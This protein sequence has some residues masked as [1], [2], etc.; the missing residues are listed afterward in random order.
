MVGRMK[1]YKQYLVAVVASLLILTGCTQSQNQDVSDQQS[2]E[3]PEV[4]ETTVYPLYFNNDIREV[5]CQ[6]ALNMPLTVAVVDYTIGSAV[7]G[8]G[9]DF[10]SCTT[11]WSGRDAFLFQIPDYGIDEVVSV[12]EV[13]ENPPYLL[14]DDPREQTCR[15]L[16]PLPVKYIQLSNLVGTVQFTFEDDST[17]TAT[18]ISPTSYSVESPEAGVDEIVNIQ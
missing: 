16:T 15:E 17:C 4:A 13:Q 14:K 9:K 11:L 6:E 8:Y 7:F 10:T 18:W 3:E 2:V 12:D 1:N 5:T